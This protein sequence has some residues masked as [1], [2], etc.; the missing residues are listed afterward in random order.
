MSLCG[1]YAKHS[2]TRALRFNDRVCLRCGLSYWDRDKA[3][4]ESPPQQSII[5]LPDAKTTR[6][7]RISPLKTVAVKSLYGHRLTAK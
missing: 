1:K 7:N 5:S 4:F 2:W 3:L 6:K